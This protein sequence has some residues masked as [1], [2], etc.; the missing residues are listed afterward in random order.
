VPTALDLTHEIAQAIDGA[1]LRGHTLA[2]GYIDDDGYP[3]VS[4]RGSTQVYGPRQ[5]ALW[6]RKRDDGFAR[7]I[8]IRPQ[9]SLVYYGPGGPS[10]VFL[11]IRGRARIDESANDAV[12]SAM[13]DG[14]QAQDPDRNGV[15]VVID[16]ETVHGF[17]A[18]GGFQLEAPAS[19]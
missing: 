6:V 16:V 19:A 13:I 4:F 10:P 12:Y 5:L 1:A 7:A 14:E 18:N 17:G 2:L 9:V 3:A 11:S 15:A 8:V